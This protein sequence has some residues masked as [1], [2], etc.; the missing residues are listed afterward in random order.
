MYVCMYLIMSETGS[1]NGFMFEPMKETNDLPHQ[2]ESQGDFD[3][4]QTASAL[5]QF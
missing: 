2:S 5:S 1:R 4:V 3:S